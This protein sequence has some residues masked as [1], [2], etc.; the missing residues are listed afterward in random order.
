MIDSLPEQDTSPAVSP[1]AVSSSILHAGPKLASSGSVRRASANFWRE[2]MYW[3]V[4]HWPPFVLF[5]R[6]FFLWF[7]LRYSKALL[8]GPTANAKR[9]LGST[10]SP[11]EVEQLR[12]AMVRN[13]YTSIYELGRAVRSTPKQL[14]DWVEQAD[15]VEHYE[16]ARAHKKGAILVTAHLGPFEIGSSPLTTREA[17]V[18]VLF[19][20][21]DRTSF[22]R[23]RSQLRQKLGVEQISVDDGWLVWAKIRDGLLNDE[24]VLIMGDRVMPGQR[25]VEVEFMGGHM[26]MPVGPVKLAMA[27]GSPIIP[28][29]SVRT[30]I[31]RCRVVIEKPIFVPQGPDMVDGHHPAMRRIAAAIERQVQ[32]YPDQWAVYERA[33]CED[34]EASP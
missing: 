14:R 12:R 20:R 32:A 9:I 28:I 26:L 25:G 4:A 11:N 8:D 23:L 13:A 17:K 1:T 2:F 34:Q 10:A 6:P 22:D 18:S 5:T 29:F 24:V 3:W 16:A 7:A 19:R 31:G 27:T 15:G 30:R 33:W 21:D